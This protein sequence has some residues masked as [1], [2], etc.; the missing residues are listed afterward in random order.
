M[1]VGAKMFFQ[2]FFECDKLLVSRA[3]VVC[4]PCVPYASL[5]RSCLT[6][7]CALRTL[8]VPCAPYMPSR[9]SVPR[10]LLVIRGLHTLR[11]LRA[12]RILRVLLVLIVLFSLNK[13][14]LRSP[15]RSVKNN[16]K[17]EAQVNLNPF[18]SKNSN[19]VFCLLCIFEIRYVLDMSCYY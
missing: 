10:A 9:I 11:G 18:S 17:E 1:V 2:T 8:C 4:M 19:Y 6:C 12:L 13:N 5:C 3:V 7:P 15:V 16:T 14:F